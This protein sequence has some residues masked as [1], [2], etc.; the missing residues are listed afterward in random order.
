MDSQY[1]DI[2]EYITTYIIPKVNNTV[3]EDNAPEDIKCNIEIYFRNPP[4][5]NDEIIRLLNIISNDDLKELCSRE[6]K[7][8]RTIKQYS[9]QY[10]LEFTDTILTYYL[11]YCNKYNININQTITHK[12][13]LNSDLTKKYYYGFDIYEITNNEIYDEIDHSIGS[14]ID[15]FCMEFITD[16]YEPISI[17][18]YIIKNCTF[19][20]IVDAFTN[21]PNNYRIYDGF[22]HDLFVNNPH[23]N[24]MTEYMENNL[25]SEEDVVNIINI[26]TVLFEFD[27]MNANYI[28]TRM[29]LSMSEIY[30]NLNY[31]YRVYYFIINKGI[32]IN[33]NIY[34][35]IYNLLAYSETHDSNRI[36]DII[37][38]FIDKGY[39]IT[40]NT[41]CDLY[42]DNNNINADLITLLKND[43]K[44]KNPTKIYITNSCSV[45]LESFKNMNDCAKVALDGCGHMFCNNCYCKQSQIKKECPTCRTPFNTQIEIIF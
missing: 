12:L 19:G 3:M 30:F 15:T 21:C 13:I 37:K 31:Y 17:Y 8:L 16:M 32:E 1:S 41:L 42:T 43:E 14:T 11:Q 22:V 20:N 24:S 10:K 4:F 40:D 29:L 34:T 36:I 45:C 26:L 28:R 9:P 33:H 18:E 39:K 38:L 5:N 27:I 25:S 35:I 7:D 2:E 23:F 44:Y 6:Y